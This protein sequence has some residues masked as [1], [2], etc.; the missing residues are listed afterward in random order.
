[1][2]VPSS[3]LEYVGMLQAHATYWTNDS[4]VDFLIATSGIESA[5]DA[6]WE[7]VRETLYGKEY[8]KRWEKQYLEG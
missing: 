8:E 5:S 2:P 7:K 4:F 3:M 1:M 6:K